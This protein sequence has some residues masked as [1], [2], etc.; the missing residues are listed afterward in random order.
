M[1]FVFTNQAQSF[2]RKNARQLALAAIVVLAIAVR[3]FALGAIPPGLNQDEAS[4][5]Y[6][7][8]A[9]LHYGIDRNGFHN[10]LVMIAWGSGMSALPEY[11]AMLAYALFGFGVASLRAVNFIFSILALLAFYATVRRSGNDK[12]ALLAAFLLAICPWHVMMARW[13]HEANLFP[14]LLM[15]AVYFLAR[16]LD[17]RPSGLVAAALLA[18]NL[19]AYAPAYAAVPVFALS[20]VAYWLGTHRMRWPH[21]LQA[22]AVFVAIALPIAAFLSINQ[23]RLAS[24][25]TALFSI[26]R[27]TSVPR[28]QT[29]A[30]VFSH[31]FVRRCAANLQELGQLL[32]SQNDG[33]IYNALPHFGIVYLFSM[34]LVAIGL[35]IAVREA[36]TRHREI[37]VYFL[38]WLFAG[39]VLS[40]LV[41]PNINRVNMIFVP[42]VFLLAVGVDALSGQRWVSWAFVTLYVCAFAW[43]C[44]DYFGK[45]P[46]QIAPQFSAGF[47]QAIRAA[48]AVPGPICVVSNVNKAYIFVL[49]YAELDPNIFVSTV[50]YENP[51][52]EYQDVRSFDRYT[53]G[54]RNCRGDVA[55]YLVD[56]GQERQFAGWHIELFD[57]YAVAS[58]QPER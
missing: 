10:P 26:P 40:A 4:T 30:S 35:V 54:L 38:L 50:V 19:Y 29:M 32:V 43:F 24:V 3:G 55:A 16:G 48:V 18:L 49:F 53:F 11:L 52:G 27:L 9:L 20:T 45:F 14:S 15:L 41:P 34:P 33:W 7:A 22:A 5:G 31:D 13:A 25:R 42:I 58:R 51:G 36:L 21:A 2:F 12:L 39:V 28:Y 56:R 44:H 17:H 57:R 8:F 46:K 23:L 6:D 47:G 1:P 37:Y